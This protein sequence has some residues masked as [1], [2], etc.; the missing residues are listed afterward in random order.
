MKLLR[1]LSV[2]IFFGSYSY[3]E[4]DSVGGHLKLNHFGST[5]SVAQEGVEG[6]INLARRDGI[7]E[8]KL[9]MYGG[10]I[11]QN[12]NFPT[13]FGPGK[14]ILSDDASLFD[15]ADTV[16]DDGNEVTY[17]RIDR[18]S[19]G[20]VAQD[21]SLR[22][23]RQALSW[24]QGLTFQVLDIINPF[25][26]AIVDSEYKPG[27]DMVFFS[28]NFPSIGELEIAYVPRRNVDTH[29]IEFTESSLAVRLQKRV[30]SLGIDTQWMVAKHYDNSM[31]G[32]GANVAYEGAI[33][34]TDILYES[35]KEQANNFSFLINVDRS[36][37]LVNLNWYGSLEYFHSGIGE[38]SNEVSNFSMQ[39][40]DK[41]QRGDIFTVG[42][43]Y[44]SV[45][46]RQELTPLLNF[47]QLWV[48]GLEPSGS[49]VQLK[50][51]YDVTQD[52][53]FTL[54]GTAGFGG[55]GSEFTGYKL[56]Q[57][58]TSSRGDTIFAQISRYF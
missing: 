4:S 33:F 49:L 19:I 39:L 54:A 11:S 31:V 24:G 8:L 14:S 35:V 53:V 3:A 6:R 16:S 25:P 44:L 32:V 57:G 5:D 1:I 23:G 15:L 28:N 45:G 56:P 12:N 10:L 51:S 47:Y 48:Q 52:V 43:D 18:F 55:S 58:I 27:T 29:D 36:W 42:K 26:P 17:G 46:I 38:K 2:L 13:T 20:W 41:L 7:L 22:L 21:S 30:E 9:D 34:R 50:I 40:S 37:E